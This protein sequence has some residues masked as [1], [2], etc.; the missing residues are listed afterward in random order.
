MLIIGML[1]SNQLIVRTG[2][3]T[4]LLPIFFLTFTFT[5]MHLADAFIQSDLQLHSGYTFLITCVHW[6]SN[7]QP[8]A[9]LTQC[10][11]TEPQEHKKNKCPLGKNKYTKMHL[12]YMY[13]MLSTV[14]YKMH[15]HIYVHN[16]ITLQFYLLKVW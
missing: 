7:P 14:Y 11:T 3:Y 16:K 12:K 9:L 6:E 1:I 2:L 10:S 5:F 4:E 13:L 15:L 8:F